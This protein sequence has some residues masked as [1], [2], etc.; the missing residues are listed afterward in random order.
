MVVTI[1]LFSQ[2][3]K[4]FT[5]WSTMQAWLCVLLPGQWMELR[6]S[7][8]SITWVGGKNTQ[9]LVNDKHVRLKQT[10]AKEQMSCQSA[11]VVTAK[12]VIS[13]GLKLLAFFSP[14][15]HLGHFF[16]TFLLLDLL[17]HSAPSRVIN[18]SSAAHLF[19]KIHFD[20]LKGE[21]DY[22]HFRAYAQSKLANVLFT[23]ELAKRTEGRDAETEILS[24]HYVSSFACLSRLPYARRKR[25]LSQQCES[26]MPQ[27]QPLWATS[28]HREISCVKDLI[29]AQQITPH[30]LIML[31][32]LPRYE[33]RLS[34]TFFF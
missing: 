7:L 18:L 11:P 20:D 6:C 1:I 30:S 13:G 32:F 33:S 31:S 22:H 14:T 26:P 28:E 4:L 27:P 21:K 5:I 3:R 23:R 2:L 25:I 19:G 9:G 15:T 10:L 34:V 17:K 12:Y 29:V 16:L 24:S 8:E